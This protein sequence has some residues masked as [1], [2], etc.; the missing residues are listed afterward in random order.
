M[1]GKEFMETLKKILSRVKLSPRAVRWIIFLVAGVAVAGAAA[2]F[3]LYLAVTSSEP[4]LPLG[5]DLYALNRPMAFTFLD[6]KGNVVGQRGAIVGERLKLSQLPP[7]LPAAFLAMEDR[8]FYQ[9]NG[10]DV[11][12]MLR[13][14]LTDI[15][16]GHIAQGGSTVTQQLSKILFLTPERTLSRKI[17]EM[18]AALALEKHLTKQQILEL[19]LNRIYLGSGAYGVDGA[20]RVYFGKSARKV[21]VAEAAMLAALT[22][23][24]TAFSPRRDLAAAQVRAGRVLDTMLATGAATPAQIAEARLNPAEVSDLT[25][26]NARDYFLD[27]AADEARHVAGSGVGDLVVVTT[28]YP[29]M[30]SAARKAITGVLDKQGDKANASQ[31]ALVAMSPDGAVRALIGGRDYA[32]STF[33][34]VT[35]AHRQPGSSFKVFVYTAALEAGLTPNT[36]RDDEPVQLGNWTPEN[37]GGT[38]WGTLTLTQALAHSVNTIAVNL[39]QEVGVQSVIAVARRLG[40]TSPLE[41]NATLA[42]GTSDVSPL[43]LT[44]AYS[45]F[46]SLGLQA[47]PYMVLEVRAPSG[48]VLFKRLKTEPERVMSEDEAKA[49]NAMLYEVIQTGTGRAAALGEREVAGK[50]GTTQDYR[51]AWFL[52]FSADLVAGVWVGNDDFTP[53]KGVTGGGLP[54]QIWSRFMSGALHNTP[55]QPLP[56]ATPEE[57]AASSLVQAQDEE[58]GAIRD[59]EARMPQPRK[60]AEHRGLFDWLFDWGSSDDEQPS[61]RRHDRRGQD[62]NNDN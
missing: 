43:E 56:R 35:Q 53:M 38:Q 22:R 5:A 23:A 17:Q 11:R 41:A 30:Q 26:D 59:D 12:G 24:P 49:M 58:A 1:L 39:E 15:L 54:A 46:A 40:I 3:A 48:A 28:L 32:E 20:A 42:L 52:G 45:S 29:A 9:H 34:R 55:L 37:Y 8:R 13:A 19:Y 57:E 36:E 7:Y 6:E 2:V 4:D 16:T 33:N 10:I 21:T 44:A 62:D 60:R 27:T 14:A 51:D 47:Q 61:S 50:T 25:E 31:A 18:S